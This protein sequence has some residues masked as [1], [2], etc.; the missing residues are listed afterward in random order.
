MLIFLTVFR[1]DTLLHSFFADIETLAGDYNGYR[2]T[3]PQQKFDMTIQSAFNVTNDLYLNVYFEIKVPHRSYTVL[4]DCVYDIYGNV[5]G[6]QEV[7]KYKA[8]IDIKDNLLHFDL[9]PGLTYAQ[10][11]MS[12]LMDHI[13]LVELE[14]LQALYNYGSDDDGINDNGTISISVPGKIDINRNDDEFDIEY[15]VYT[16]L[17]E[18]NTTALTLKRLGPILSVSDATVHPSNGVEA[19]D[20]INYN[21]QVD[22]QQSTEDALA[23]QVRNH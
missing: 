20:T 18:S 16:N 22:H 15:R 3:Y 21:I 9:S 19:G 6:C 14:G 23:V 17:G 13:L 12:L 4:E 2:A 10:Y 1:Q 8:F 11:H 5:T 7:T